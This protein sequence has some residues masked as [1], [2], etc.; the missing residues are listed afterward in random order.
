MVTLE[1]ATSRTEGTFATSARTS[2]QLTSSLFLYVCVSYT[3][4]C[5][6]ERKIILG[7]KLESCFMF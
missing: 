2:C 7:V 3:C 5:R 4:K 1:S 6:T